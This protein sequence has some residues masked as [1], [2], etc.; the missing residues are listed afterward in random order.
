MTIIL[1]LLPLNNLVIV[2]IL[3]TSMLKNVINKQE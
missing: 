3:K 1:L 2:D